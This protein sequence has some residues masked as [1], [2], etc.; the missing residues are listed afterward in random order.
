MTEEKR[1][2]SAGAIVVAALT[3]AGVGFAAGRFAISS[4]AATSLAE[5]LVRQTNISTAAPL[6]AAAMTGS[7]AIAG[8]IILPV[9]VGRLLTQIDKENRNT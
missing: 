7:A 4:G 9:V 1:S 3:G 8:A 2:R 6:L 5:A